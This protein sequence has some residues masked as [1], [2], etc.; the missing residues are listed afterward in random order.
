MVLPLSLVMFG[1]E[2]GG[3]AEE[4]IDGWEWVEDGSLSPDS[5]AAK[6]CIQQINTHIQKTIALACVSV[7]ALTKYFHLL[8]LNIQFQGIRVFHY[9]NTLQKLI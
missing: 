5:I 6:H 2:A 7:K 9:V 1:D 4:L 3:V 8:H